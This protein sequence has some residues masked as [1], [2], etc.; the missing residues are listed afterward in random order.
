MC[1][2]SIPNA[3]QSLM[4]SL[5]FEHN[6]L[7]SSLSWSSSTSAVVRREEANRIQNFNKSVQSACVDVGN[8]GLSNVILHSVGNQYH[9]T[10]L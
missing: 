8:R 9:F 4:V 5:N 2:N 7:Q 6:P 3:I 1:I 10:M